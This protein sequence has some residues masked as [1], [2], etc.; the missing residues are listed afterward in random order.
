[1]GQIGPAF[2]AYSLV[3]LASLSLAHAQ[4]SPAELDR[5]RRVFETHCAFCHGPRGE[6]GK[7]PTLA[8]PSLPR[9]TDLS[10]LRQIIRRGIP[11]TEMPGS[12]ML[13]EDLA[14]VAAFVQEL[15]RLPPEPVPG[16]AARGAQLYAAKG[17]CAQCHAIRGQG[18]A[19]GPDLSDIGR[20]RSV[21]HLKRALVEPAAEVP[22]S[23]S[24]QRGE[25]GMPANF[26]LVRVVPRR[27]APVAGVRVNEDTFSLQMRDL[28]G[29]VHSF[30]KSDLAEFHKD[31][32]T[33]PMPAYGG[34]FN[35]TELDDLVAFLVSLRTDAAAPPPTQPVVPHAP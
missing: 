4:N 8:Q 31:W 25:G 10:A 1:V 28:A 5:G 34:V 23:F 27:G 7:G 11:N 9:A 13:P 30:F 32:G 20:T 14:S 12:R 3:A 24:A 17:A 2:A 22:Q 15:G 29:K 26:L 16:N 18:G 35:S 6:G 21:A 33:T 19:I